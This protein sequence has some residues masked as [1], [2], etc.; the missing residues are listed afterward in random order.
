MYTQEADDLRVKL[1][2]LI[3]SSAEEWDIKNAVRV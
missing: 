2:R 1:D 3:G